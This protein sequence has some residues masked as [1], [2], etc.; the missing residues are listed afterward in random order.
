LSGMKER[1][2]RIGAKLS[3]SSATEAGTELDLTIPGHLAFEPPNW[4]GRRVQSEAR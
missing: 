3:I 4:A 2:A 1:S